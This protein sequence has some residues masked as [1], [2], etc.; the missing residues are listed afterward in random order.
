MSTKMRRRHP[1]DAKDQRRTRRPDPRASSTRVPNK[2][3]VIRALRSMPE[4]S[5]SLHEL[6]RA[7]RLHDKAGKDALHE[8]VQNLL[9]QGEI[10]HVGK[11]LKLSGS[12]ELTGELTAHP[13]GYG[14]VRLG[15]SRDDDAFI[16]PDQMAGL[17]H[18]DRIAVRLVRRR[19]RQ[20]AEVLRIVETA[21]NTITGQ[22]SVY[23]GLGIVTPRS[24]RM[25][26]PISI[27]SKDANGAHDGDWVRVEINRGSAPPQGRVTEVLGDVMRPSRLIDLVVAEQGL[28]GPFKPAVLEEAQATPETIRPADS[29]DRL[30]LTHLPFVTIDGE[31]AK[32]FD[33]AICVT[34]RGEGFE[35]WVAIADVAHYVR[36]GTHLDIEARIRGNSFYFP[37][38]VIP[39]LPER[40]SNGICSLKPD[41]T[42]LAMAVRMRYDA[43]GRRRSVHVHETMIR[44]Q[45]RLTYGQVGRW[46][47]GADASAIDSAALREMLSHSLA[48]YRRMDKHRRQRGALELD[49]PEIRAVIENDEMHSLQLREQGVAHRLIEECMLAANTAVVGF[50]EA[51]GVALLYRVHE[52]PAPKSLATLNDFLAPLGV[53]IRLHDSRQIHPKQLQQVIDHL[54]DPATSHVLHRLILRS[55]QQACY[56]PENAGHFGLAY[57]AY[58]HF[59]SPIRRYADIT[60]HRRLKAVLNNASPEET[61]PAS[62]LA[63]IGE[64]TSRQERR[65]MQAERDSSAMLSSLYHSGDAGKAF[66][67]VVSGLTEQRLFFELQ[68]SC[69]EASMAVADLGKR[70]SFDARMHRLTEHASGHAFALGDKVSVRIDSTDPVR[71]IIRVSLA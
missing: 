52:P 15:K 43:G 33:D 25:P 44:S 55:M 68:P 34:P 36:P 59:T 71:G 37:D 32:D 38:R 66:Q 31:D 16:P 70:Y 27:R 22:F 60:V 65:Q 57:K 62:E 40:L 9:Q 56:T 30:D 41:E 17:M 47:E 58:A 5:A 54:Q 12:P 29:K 53:A 42:R 49:L 26:G 24:R 20:S 3:A 67:A 7:L 45:A 4:R 13:D 39:M 63:N 18:G 23:G 64:E 48:L 1:R 19:G 11:R 51:K 50:L 46:L 6:E 14:F 8:C 28:P 2:G 21:A 35:L 69:A 10:S 61:Q